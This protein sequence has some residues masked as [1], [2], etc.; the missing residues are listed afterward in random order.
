MND[1]NDTN[2]PSGPEAG[3]ARPKRRLTRSRD[4]RYIGG[5]AA[6][7][8]GYFGID[9]TLVRVAFAVSLV[10]G[11]AGVLA[12]LVLL[13]LVPLEGDPDQ[14]APPVTGTRRN[15][16]I[17]GTV[18]VGVL[19]VVASLS[20][21]SGTS[22][23]FGFGPGVLFGILLWV[24]VG[25]GLGWALSRTARPGPR[26]PEHGT[27]EADR[28]EPHRP[29]ASGFAPSPSQV[30]PASAAAAGGE[31]DAE[32]G[33]L[34]PET[35]QTETRAAAAASTPGAGDGGSTA[36]SGTPSTFGRI[37]TWLAIAFT[38]IVLLSILAV[39]SFGIT[40]VF[41]AI[42]AAVLVIGCGAGVVA[43]A[44]N[45]RPQMAL[46][47]T[48][49]AVA[50]AIP[51]AVVSIASLDIEGDWGEINERPLTRASIPADGYQMAAG[52]LKVDLRDFPFRRG[53]TV[54][55][56]TD[57]GF[58][59]TS[60]IVPDDVCV[61]GQV[62]GRVGYIDIRGSDRS[63]VDVEATREPPR[64][65]VPVLKLSSDFRIGYFGVFDDS[66]WRGSGDDWPDDLENRDRP[67]AVSRA[68]EACAGAAGDDRPGKG[69]RN[70]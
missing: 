5:V 11:G 27:T 28:P 54:E 21:G 39:I 26:A 63:G 60:V 14:P 47:T 4:D 7:L 53:Q 61:V 38:G 65:D 30:P 16:A 19:L 66:G 1:Y 31:P 52:A 58:G 20:G 23:L 9:P 69:S 40:A 37:M 17:G 22:W 36:A 55:L 43:L 70:G 2:D 10:I 57:S 29:P 51:M 3:S 45:D 12:Y 62:E 67:G 64:A 33:V 15:V 68:A 48:A 56:E 42:P 32:T 50:I 25:A 34:E 44:L 8:A 24:L 18:L 6:G 46:W 13:A 59:A 49:A 41:G 35:A